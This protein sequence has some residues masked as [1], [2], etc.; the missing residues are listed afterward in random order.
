MKHGVPS[1][2]RRPL[3]SHEHYQRN[4]DQHHEE[5]KRGH[6]NIYTAAR[7]GLSGSASSPNQQP[8]Q[9]CSR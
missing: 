6:N 3:T 5:E 4:H 2:L 1:V 9:D 8:D 7:A